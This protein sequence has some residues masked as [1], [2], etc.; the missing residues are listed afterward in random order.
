M[1]LHIRP[2]VRSDASQI[3]TFILELARYEKAEHQVVAT[4]PDIEQSLFA[5]DSPAQALIC[6]VEGQ[7]IGFAVYYYAY[8][9]WLGRKS[10][11]LEDLYVSPERR[12]L[13]A[14]KA[15][16]AYLARVACES[17]CR[18]MEWMVMEWNEPAL[19][20]YRRLG[21]G[22]LED[23][24]RYRLADDALQALAETRPT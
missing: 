21:A 6:E 16:L 14:G 13:G 8:S 15:L 23:L 24:V 12:G 4:V 7:P 11:Y 2:A 20:F 10:L 19:A 3:L 18:R 17:G 22:P 1:S 5:S 9:T